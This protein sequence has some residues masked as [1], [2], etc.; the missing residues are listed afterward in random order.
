[1]KKTLFLLVA[2][3]FISFLKSAKV[4]AYVIPQQDTNARAFYVFGPDGNPLVGAE[5][6]TMEIFID[7]PAD[8]RSSLTIEVYDPDTGN[9]FDWREP[10]YEVDF[11]P[12]LN[13][14]NT[15]CVFELHGETL[16]DSTEFALSPEWDR[17]WYLFG[18]YDK[19]EGEKVG[20]YYRFRL[21]ATG[22]SGDDQNLFRVRISPESA[23][24]YA[25]KV[26]IR[27]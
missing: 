12:V 17:R 4:Q 2:V 9:F 13:E 15:T 21:V 19:S 11:K 25:E 18:P 6:S 5:D 26:K 14:W 10:L 27:L 1:M 24:S 3:L 23:E 16:L 8:E 20:D 7:V 22:I